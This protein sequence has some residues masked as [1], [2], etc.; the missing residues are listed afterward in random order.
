[1]ASQLVDMLGIPEDQ[2][3]ALL[4]AAGGSVELAMNLHFGGGDD[5]G[6]GGGGS[7]F[8]KPFDWYTLVWPEEREIP[9]SWLQQDLVFCNDKN[10]KI[11]LV[12]KKNGPCGMLSIIQSYIIETLMDK[13]GTVDVN[14]TPSDEI[15]SIAIS[16]CLQ[17][18]ASKTPTPDTIQLASWKDSIGGEINT[19]AIKLSDLLPAITSKISDFK[20][21]GG[22]ILIMYS[23]LLTR[24]IDQV[25]KDIEMDVGEPP[26]VLAPCFICSSELFGL[27]FR[28]IA[29]GNTSSYTVTGEKQDWD[30]KIGILSTLEQEA[31]VPLADTLK[32]PPKPIWIIHGGDHFTTLFH[33]IADADKAEFDLWH[34]NGL[35]PSGPDMSRLEII[36]PNGTCKPA[37]E[38]HVERFKKPVV[39]TI[40]DIVQTKEEDKKNKPGRYQ[41]WTYEAVLAIN[42]PEVSGEQELPSDDNPVFTTPPTGPWRCASCYHSRFKTMCF[43]LNDDTPECK[44]CNRPRQEALWSLWL[45]YSELPKHAKNL[46]TKMFAP[47]IHVLLTTR[48]PGC[49]FKGDPEEAPSI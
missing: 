23:G 18:S 19:T 31:G 34:W 6:G 13:N 44:F 36:A 25:K 3:A 43:G 49:T 4:E 33:Q 35:P 24:G 46:A 42:D 21:A 47:K 22:I 15:L 17:A 39:G 1:M 41:E 8:Q 48:W 30:S 28:G 37:P 38:K 14:T 45:H 20:S 11:G 10:C 29:G 7:Q 27:F 9:E 26:L 12:Q 2:A 5:M 16:K 32:N 40:Y